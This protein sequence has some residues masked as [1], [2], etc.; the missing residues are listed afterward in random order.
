MKLS[1]TA[2]LLALA[3]TAS[4][5]AIQ[6]PVA[7]NAAGSAARKRHPRLSKRATIT[8]SLV[9][10][11]TEGG[12]YASVSVGTPGQA[13]TMVL[14]TGSSDGFVISADADLCTEKRLQLLYDETCGATYNSSESSTYKDLIPDGFEIEYADGTTAEGSYIT[15]DFSIGGKT[16]K[17]LQL[18]L[19]SQ[20][21]VGTGILGIGF[22]LN[23]AAEKQYSNLVASMANQSLIPTMAY[24]LYL[25]DYYSSMGSIVFGGVD[26][27][28]FIGNLNTVPILKDS[29]SGEYSSFTVGLS[30]LEFAF[31][32]GTSY[33]QSLSSEGG[34]LDS[35]LDSGTT[36]T[37][38]PDTIAT[39][40]FEAVG[41]Y[42]YS[43]FL[44][45]STLAIVDCALDLNFTFRINST[46]TIVVPRDELVLDVL[47]G[48][49]GDDS[50]PSD[51]P[52]ANPCLFG[53]Q[54]MGDESEE[55][56]GGGGDSTSISTSTD[57]AIL[58]DSFLRSAYV[59]YDLDNLQIG[60]AQANLNSTSSN[61]QELSADA[62]GLPAF[63]GV[64]SQTASSPTSSSGSGSSS[65]SSGT[66]TASGSSASGTSTSASGEASCTSGLSLVVVLLFV[67]C[68]LVG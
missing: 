37:Y 55:S 28:K 47:T 2:T 15:D 11:V 19:A 51:I 43:E 20:T 1:D 27:D 45:E 54:N 22:E 26:T 53:I 44:S 62:S 41:A 29:V 64:A 46:A 32:N 56:G 48:S 34:T 33:T 36:L 17:N 23:E 13:L 3:A 61:V 12:Y 35:I 66:S 7:R 63:S 6:L 58:G 5:E 31:A 42:Q 65:S 21:A 14:D 24:S 49:D 8:E 68:C 4:A 60:I 38:L 57:Y 39:P 9:N 16:V 10:N 52:F 50:L 30:G 18:G 67:S 40:L 25:N 59:V